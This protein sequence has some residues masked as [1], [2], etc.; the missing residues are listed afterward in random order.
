ML[1]IQEEEVNKPLGYNIVLGFLKKLDIAIA[2]LYVGINTRPY[3]TIRIQ[4]RRVELLHYY[5]I[6]IFNDSIF[7]ADD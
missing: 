4:V 3:I 2:Y 1:V 6:I 5:T 7:Q